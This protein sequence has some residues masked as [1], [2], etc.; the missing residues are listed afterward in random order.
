MFYVYEWFIVGTGE[1]IYVGKGTRLRYKVRKHNKI[2]NEMIK[3]FPCDSRIVKEFETEKEAFEYEYEHV[4]ELQAKGEC[5]CNLID[6]GKGGTTNWW[7]DERRKEYSE[8]NVM[9]SEKQRQRMSEKNPMKDKRISAKVNSRK[10]KAVIIDGKEYESVRAVCEAYGV[11]S[12]TIASWCKKGINASGEVCK[13]K[14]E[15]Q[16]IFTDKRY[17]KGGCRPLT[18]KGKAYETPKDLADELGL[19]KGVVLRWVKNGF[20]AY[21]NPCRYNDDTRELTF[22]IKRKSH[23]A[24]VVNGVHYRTFAEAGRANGV[25]AQTIAD[26]TNH[27]YSNPK[28]ICEYDIQQ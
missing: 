21:G 26:L 16:A 11:S 10:R 4:K 9:K 3:R 15:E 1:I 20:D 6:G 2:F 13:Y 27:K 8:R 19:K 28:F 18:Y 22:E 24:V 17:N 14:D 5:V 23:H 12:Q 7:N 25:S